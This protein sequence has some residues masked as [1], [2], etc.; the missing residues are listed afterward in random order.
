MEALNIKDAKKLYL[1]NGTG[2]VQV[3]SVWLGANLVWPSLSKPVI[4]SA[5]HQFVEAPTIADT[6]YYVSFVWDLVS[7]ANE[8]W[9]YVDGVKRAELGANDDSYEAGVFEYGDTVAVQVLARGPGAS[10]RMSDT[11]NIIIEDPV[12]SGNTISFELVASKTNLYSW[13]TGDDVKMYACFPTWMNTARINNYISRYYQYLQT[14]PSVTGYT[15]Y[16]YSGTGSAIISG[17]PIDIQPIINTVDIY[18]GTLVKLSDG[19][20][21]AYAN[22]ILLDSAFLPG[23]S[24]VS[25]SFYDTVVQRFNTW[26]YNN[27]GTDQTYR[28]YP[29]NSVGGVEDALPEQN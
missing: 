13:T 21:A 27:S 24:V 1:G 2:R 6:G 18:P 5:Y 20:S 8:Y 4:T 16:Y 9:I 15:K 23:S 26:K 29:T 11:T 3:A 22:I 19:S 12:Y 14:Y 10:Q 28:F 25:C 7:G 17:M